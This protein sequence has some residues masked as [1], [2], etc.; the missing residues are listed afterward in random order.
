MLGRYKVAQV[1]HAYVDAI[2]RAITKRAPY[3]ANRTLALLSKMFSLAIK[4]GW[5]SD[6]PAR[7]VERNQ[8]QRRE[9]YLTPD[10]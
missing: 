6:N 10:E 5:R 9:R 2:H 3:R 4:W 7:W 8:E 1:S